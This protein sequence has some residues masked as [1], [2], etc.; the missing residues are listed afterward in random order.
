M[1]RDI[2]NEK[3]ANILV[4]LSENIDELFLTK[5]LK[6]LYI[7][8]ETA[9]KE[10]GCPITWLDYKFWRLGPVPDSIYDELNSLDN[11]KS[12]C[13]SLKDYLIRFETK[14]RHD[15]N[16]KSNIIK[17]KPGIKF[18][19]MLFS[20]YEIELF[21]R[22]VEANKNKSSSDL[23][24]ELHKEGS[25]YHDLE[26]N[27]PDLERILEI[28]DGKSNFSVE[29]SKLLIDDPLKQELY[30]SIHNSLEFKNSMMNL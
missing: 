24:K 22:V 21:T 25:L 20:E 15:D 23:V 17:A 4:F 28:N 6:L 18:N 26:S 29:F 14:N 9:V 11:D 8:D 5:A 10:S 16:R 30:K 7:I 3:I 1:Y 12:G 19:K 2:L 13:N 27:I